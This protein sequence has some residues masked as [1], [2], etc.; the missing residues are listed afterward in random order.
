M[1]FLS[2]VL[3]LLNAK[4]LVHL[5]KTIQVQNLIILILQ[6]RHPFSLCKAGRPTTCNITKTLQILLSLYSL[7]HCFSNF[8]VHILQMGILLRCKLLFSLGWGPDA[9]F[10]T[11]F[12]EMLLLLDCSKLNHSTHQATPHLF[13]V[14]KTTVVPVRNEIVEILRVIHESLCSILSFSSIPD[15]IVCLA[16]PT[17]SSKSN[18]NSPKLAL[19]QIK[20]YNP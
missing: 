17:R 5:Q 12:G 8:D 6:L 1:T 20:F 18:F 14:D 19:K 4:K 13:R 16:T 10:I 7:D 9:V 3:L 15:E 11:K 2:A